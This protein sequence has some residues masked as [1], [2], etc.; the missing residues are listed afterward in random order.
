MPDSAVTSKVF[1]D[2]EVFDAQG[3]DFGSPNIVRLVRL[4]A[5]HKV[6]IFLTTVTVKEIERHLDEHAVKAFKQLQ[7]YRRA[8]HIVKKV[9]P[10]ET[11]VAL[12]DANLESIRSHLRND[13]EAFVREGHIQILTLDDVS[14]TSVFDKYF[15]QQPPFGD[16]GKKNEFP[17]AFACAA[18]KVWCTKNKSRMYVVSADPDWRR[19]CTNEPTLVHLQRLDELLEQFAD[20]VVVTAIKESLTARMNELRTLI[21]ADADDLEYFVSDNVIDGEYEDVELDIEIEDFHVVEAA[22]GHAIV[23]ASCVLDIQAIVRGDDPDSIWRDPDTGDMNSVW[24]VSGSIEQQTELD[25]TIAVTY[26]VNR[27]EHITIGR[28][29]FDDR[30]IEL[31]V[32]DDQLT[33]DDDDESDEMDFTVPD[34]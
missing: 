3:L 25:A 2:T 31:D 21:N 15:A 22:N 26:D 6:Q 9:L 19:A 33:R 8:S 18:L 23:T 12:S 32:D 27:P 16:K 14:A 28:V 34:D 10:A 30:S 29:R 17:D 1:I 7:D 24:R 11:A 5:A 13:F 4:A 20:S